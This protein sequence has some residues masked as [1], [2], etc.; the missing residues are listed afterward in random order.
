MTETVLCLDTSVLVKFLTPEGPEEQDRAAE[1]LVVRGVTGEARLVGPAMVWAE[2]G[3]VLMK[4]TRMGVLLPSE[5]QDLWGVLMRLPIELVETP[6]LRW[7]AWDI[8]RQHS[9]PTLYDA[10]FLAC[11]ELAPASEGIAREFW[12]ADKEFLR[13]LGSKRPDYVREFG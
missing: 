6:G 13:R 10:L 7:R 3:S 11:T 4:K 9:L 12:T 1:E 5:A 2:V 8:A